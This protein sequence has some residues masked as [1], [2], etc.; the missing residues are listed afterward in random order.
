MTSL[1]QL[2]FQTRFFKISSKI[3]ECIC[4]SNLFVFPL[5]ML[6]TYHKL[7]Q[8]IRSKILSIVLSHLGIIGMG[9]GESCCQLLGKLTCV[10]LNTM[11][12]TKMDVN[13]QILTSL[14]ICCKSSHPSKFIP[15]SLSMID[16]SE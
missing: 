1:F 8:I 9:E 4:L 14:Q 16:V 7:Q 2:V 15:S 3:S 12:A 11:A 6:P 5:G 13:L 10:D